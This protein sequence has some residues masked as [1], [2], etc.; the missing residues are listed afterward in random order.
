MDLRH[1]TMIEAVL[2]QLIATGATDPGKVFGQDS[3][4][5]GYACQPVTEHNM[6]NEQGSISIDYACQPAIE[7]TMNTI[8]GCGTW[9]I[10]LFWC[11]S[12]RSTTFHRNNGLK[13]DGSLPGYRRWKA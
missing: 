9:I 5:V 4:C 3:I 6:N 12:T 8:M 11:G 10:R 7:Y 13:P 1:D 2:E